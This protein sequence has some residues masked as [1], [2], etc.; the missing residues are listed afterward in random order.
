MERLACHDAAHPPIVAG[1]R[2]LT[3]GQ[4]TA[5]EPDTRHFGL[6]GSMLAA[7]GLD[8]TCDRA[9]EQIGAVVTDLSYRSAG[10]RVITL[11]NGQVW[12]Q[13][14]SSGLGHVAVGDRVV[15]RKAALGSFLLITPARVSL[16]VRRID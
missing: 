3:R 13:T 7:Q 4:G 12:M 8:C 1:A 5:G 2:P 15:V 10:Q 6:S 16:R 9:P 11:D 14:E